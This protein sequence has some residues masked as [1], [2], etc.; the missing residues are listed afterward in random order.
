MQS[1]QLELN[2]VIRSA[3]NSEIC[4]YRVVVCQTT[5]LTDSPAKYGFSVDLYNG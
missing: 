3:R 5:A 1:A 2:G 4:Y